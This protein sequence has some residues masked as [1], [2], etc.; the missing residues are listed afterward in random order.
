MIGDSAFN[1]DLDSENFKLCRSEQFAVQ[2]Y[3]FTTN[4][5]SKPFILE[6]YEVDQ[7][8]QDNYNTQNVKKESGLFRIRFIINCEGEAGRYRT[9][10]MDMDYNE[11]VFDTTITDQLLNITQ[12][13]LK[14]RPYK[15]GNVQRD[16]YMYLI[17]KLRN[18]EIVEIMP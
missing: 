8:F 18:G 9:L 14:W 12:Q 11:K 6:K 16:Y 17:F 4:I 15:N 2:Y 7:I 13:H 1:P 3:A 10:G 5:G